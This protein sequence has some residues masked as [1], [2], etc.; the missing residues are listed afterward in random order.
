[1]ARETCDTQPAI[2]S[3]L[4]KGPKRWSAIRRLLINISSAAFLVLSGI[5]GYECAASA[6]KQ[7]TTQPRPKPRK[8]KGLHVGYEP[9]ARER[10]VT[11]CETPERT[12]KE[13]IRKA[14]KKIR[15][16][17]HSNCSDPNGVEVTYEDG[18]LCFSCETP[19]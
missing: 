4:E 18:E 11:L 19:F 1:M 8:S 16:S 10:T 6:K 14:R 7:E 13:G 2:R 3:T 12:T 9:P 5:S 17:L 15:K